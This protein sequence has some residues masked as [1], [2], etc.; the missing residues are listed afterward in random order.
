VL[1]EQRNWYLSKSGY[2][3]SG[4]RTNAHVFLHRHL[5]GVIPDDHVVDHINRDKLDNR[6][7][8]L[9]VLTRQENTFNRGVKRNK[10]DTPFKGVRRAGRRWEARITVGDILRS[11]G[12][13]ATAEEAARGYDA[14]ARLHHRGRAPLNFPGTGEFDLNGVRH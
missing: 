10:R 9:R 11:V 4:C 7:T 5:M 13:F 3:V 2:V 8:N 6:R 14:A 1:A 12:F